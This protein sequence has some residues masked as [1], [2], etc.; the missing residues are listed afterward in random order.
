MIAAAPSALQTTPTRRIAYGDVRPAARATTNTAATV[1]SAPRKAARGTTGETGSAPAMSA[2][3]PATAA[4]ADTPRR[5]GSAS[6]L[7]SIA[8][9]EAPEQASAPPTPAPSSTRGSRVRTRI[10]KSGVLS[11]PGPSAVRRLART[12]PMRVAAASDTTSASASSADVAARRRRVRW[13]AATRGLSG[14]AGLGVNGGGQHGG[15]LS[16][17]R[18][19]AEERVRREG[20]DPAVAHRRDCPERGEQVAAARFAP[21]RRVEDDVGRPRNDRLER[22]LREGGPGVR[23]HVH[24]ARRPQQLILQRTAAGD[25]EGAVADDQ[26]HPPGRQPGDPFVDRLEVATYPARHR[27]TS[28]GDAE[29]VCNRRNGRPEVVQGAVGGDQH[30]DPR[31]LEPSHG[32]PIPRRRHGQHQVRSDSQD[33]LH[34]GGEVSPHLWQLRRLLGIVALGADTYEPALLAEPVDDL[35]EGRRQGNDASWRHRL[36]RG[37]SAPQEQGPK[38]QDQDQAYCPFGGQ[39]PSS[40]GHS[41]RPATRA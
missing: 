26:Q 21:H 23:C 37:F 34:A 19:G 36:R 12:G 3:A 32:L 29:R 38:E 27:R 16:H 2:I 13:V 8:C 40:H 4:P 30:A 7:P 17:P 9:S 35:G 15:G 14:A 10:T 5:W 41:L 39:Q 20:D 31:S 33:R 1:P 25:D 6:G 22:Y 11:P 28:F 24:T 18:S